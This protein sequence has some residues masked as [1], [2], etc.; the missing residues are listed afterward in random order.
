MFERLNA[1]SR[2]D[3]WVL[4]L[5]GDRT[6]KPYLQ[7]RLNERG[8]AVSPDGRWLAYVSDESGSD[9]VYV[10]GFPE[11]SAAV[12]ISDD[13][14]REPRWAPDGR[15]LFYRGS[16]GMVAV[17]V[18]LTPTFRARS[19]RVLFDDDQYVKSEDRQAAYDVH[20][21]GQRFLMT[22]RGPGKDQ[23]VVL[24]NWLGQSR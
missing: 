11:P 20:P 3:I 19:A 15:E 10:A 17:A 24:M 6:P 2:G 13:G 1:S 12:R 23:V 4:P 18:D 5:N 14:G 22:Q 9:E 7:T 16:R 21:D 8:P